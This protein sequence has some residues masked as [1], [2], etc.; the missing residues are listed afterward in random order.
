MRNME[1]KLEKEV[2][3]RRFYLTVTANTLTR[4]FLKG[5]EASK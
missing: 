1:D 5:L 3:C 4:K 2:V